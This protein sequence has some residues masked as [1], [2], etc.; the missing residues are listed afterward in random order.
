MKPYSGGINMDYSLYIKTV[1]DTIE[2]RI[3]EEITLGELASITGF[4]AEH[5]R[6]VFVSAIG[7]G[8]AEYIR[9]RKLCY[10]AAALSNTKKKVT[11]IAMEYGFSSLDDFG[12]AF[13]RTFGETPTSFRRKG[14]RV[15]SKMI[16]PFVYGPAV[17]GTKRDIISFHNDMQHGNAVLYGVSKVGYYVEHREMTPFISSLK[18]ILS[19]LGQQ[20]AY[21]KLMVS[22]GAAFRLIWNN[23]FWDESNVD[24]MRMWTNP[25]LP[26]MKAVA[27]VG[28]GFKITLK[29]DFQKV[30]CVDEAIAVRSDISFG[31]KENFINLIKSEINA[32]RPVIAFGIIGPPEACIITG[33]KENGEVLLGWNYFQEMIDYA[34][35]IEKESC[36]Y[37]IKRNWYENP[38]TIAVMALGEIKESVDEKAVFVD[39]IEQALKIM[40]PRNINNAVGGLSAFESWSNSISDNYQFPMNAPLPMMYNRLICQTD[41]EVQVAEGR[42]YAA[43]YL[44]SAKKLFPDSSE[45]VDKVI[46]IFRHQVNL[47]EKMITLHEGSGFGEKHIAALCKVEV[48]KE[49]VNLIHKI[50]KYESQA[51]KGLTEI[52]E[53][54]KNI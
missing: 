26:H 13:R 15:Y 23:D 10:T 5:F 11:D 8:V 17:E 31:D 50:A 22:S 41:A 52:L 12:R 36:G 25:M 54:I 30:Y 44:E 32:G 3:S 21:C 18:S 1:L 2:N 35:D 27:S 39:A 51:I 7:Q 9:E 45:V 19:Y 49:I 29:K 47:V 46:N 14:I 53:S 43:M 20:V 33:Y 24:L 6:K 4:S 37:F 28:R 38:N 48:R 40:L 34:G 42:Y 16:V